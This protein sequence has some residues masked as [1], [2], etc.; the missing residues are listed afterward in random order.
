M[1]LTKI[2]GQVINDSTGLVVGVTTVGGGLSATDGFFSGIVT[3]VGNASFSGNLTVGGV[4][5]YEDVTNVDS[6]GLI[7]ARNGI[8]VGSGITL[9][10]DGDIFATGITTISENLKVGTGVTISPDGDAFFTGVCTATSFSGD[11]SALTGLSGVSVA[12]QSDN[13]VITNTGTTDALNAEAN[14]TF[15]GSDLTITNPD[16]SNKGIKLTATGNYYPS[17]AFDANRGAEN[18]AIVYIR[19]SW[20][21]TEVGALSVEAGDDTTNKDDGKVTFYTAQG[22]TMTRKMAIEQDGDVHIDTGNVVIGT[23]GKGID[24]SATGGPTNGSGTSELLDDYEEGTFTPTAR[25][26]NN[27]SSPVIE[28]SGKYVKIGRVV[29]IQLAFANEN[30]SYLPSG[31]YIQIHGL[32]FTFDGE[33]F[34]PYGFNY[35]VEFNSSDHYLF[36]SP[37]GGT[38]LDGYYNRSDLPY[39]PWGTDQWDNTQWYHSNSFSYLTS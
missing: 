15:D 19:G 12:N 38:R 25:G 34:I 31:E 28:G 39:Q 27:N 6:V 23:S 4:L 18:N 35:K 20:N 21:G 11:G 10:K 1:A 26:N 24:F 17:I 2:T 7:T 22:G 29:Q 32:P 33:H 36:Y 16:T 8:V 13:R 3:A 14:L 5:T 9:S 30:G 37:S